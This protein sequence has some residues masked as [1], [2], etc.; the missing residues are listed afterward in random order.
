MADHEIQSFIDT[1]PLVDHHCHS[2]VPLP[3]TADEAVDFV[4][5][6]LTEARGAAR[7]D[8]LNSIAV[9]VSD[10]QEAATAFR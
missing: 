10:R 8:A 1:C 5:A 6:S 7:K 3:Q 4:L 2:L 9:K